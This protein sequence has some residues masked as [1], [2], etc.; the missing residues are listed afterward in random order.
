MMTRR[1]YIIS[2]LIVAVLAVFLLLR[3]NSPTSRRVISFFIS[4]TPT[5]TPIPTATSTPTPTP[6][7]TPTPTP[8]PTA[9]P[10]PLPTPTPMPQSSYE[11]DFDSASS[12]YNVS[13]D[14]L[15]KIAMCESGINPAA[16]NGPYGGMF[17]FTSETWVSTRRQMGK[18][19]NPDLRFNAKE[20]IDT[21][22]YK[23]SNGGENAWAN[24]L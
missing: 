22:A 17:Q 8:L 12:Q 21:A 18:D 19:E 11:S 16:V 5:A 1:N 4:P 14:K 3:K 15:K 2:A 9:T 20:S 13:K 7:S 24:C 6:T 23:I 10:S